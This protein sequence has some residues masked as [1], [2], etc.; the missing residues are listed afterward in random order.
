[1]SIA[2]N[3]VLIDAGYEKYCYPPYMRARGHG[4]GVGSS[5]PG[6]AIDYE[7]KLN[8]ERNQAVVIHP[9]QYVPET[10]YLACGETYLVTDTGAERLAE[11]ETKLYIKEV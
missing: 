6:I 7:T 11:T 10:C 3:K 9:N 8:F 4:V 1:M 5:S 2:M